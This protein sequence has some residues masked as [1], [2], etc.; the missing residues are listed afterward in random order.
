MAEAEAEEEVKVDINTANPV[1][2]A[3]KYISQN[4]V[5]DMIEVFLFSNQFTLFTVFQFLN[6]H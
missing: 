1:N 4:D 6:V 2:T 3:W 5:V